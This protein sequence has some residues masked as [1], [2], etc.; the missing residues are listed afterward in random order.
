MRGTG[1][2]A[3]IIVQNLP[4]PLDRRVW[5]ESKALTA[6]GY[7]VSVICP[8]GPDDPSYQEL[9]EIRIYKY[10]PPREAQGL[11]GFAY[12]FGYC[13]LATFLL[14]LRV[15]RR[16]RFDVIQSCNPPDTFGFL[17][18]FYKKLFGVR[19]IFDQ[20]DLCPEVYRSRFDRPSRHVLRILEFFER[21]NYRVADHV[22]ATNESYRE[23]AMTRGQRKPDEV[24]V[25]RSGPDT[26]VMRPGEPVPELRHGRDHLLVWLGIMGPQDGV[27][28]VLHTAEVLRRDFG[29]D[30]VH[31]AL[32]GFGDC[33][34]ELKEL[35]SKLGL[36]DRVT[37]TGRADAQTISSYLSTATVGMSPDPMNP[38]NN[39]STMNKTMEYM[40]FGVPVVAFDLKETRVSAGDAAV[41]VEPDDIKGFAAAISDLLDAPHR[42]AEMARVGRRRA[43]EVLDWRPQAA[44]Y[45]A[46][47]DAVT[48]YGPRVVNADRRRV[49]V[50]VLVD[51]RTAGERRATVR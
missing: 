30:D 21:T 18:A 37:F 4:V 13:W 1:T 9:E 25:V 20:H 32:L 49:D 48:G 17:A 31:I 39:L 43:V 41:M 46:V 14:S 40:A 23:I 22:I 19:F 29:R 28:G 26:S 16:E 24:T 45:V 47:F 33:L 7:R 38:L 3:L 42:R 34:E 51:R 50:V 8:K 35:S 15:F 11:V 5:L 2:H 12:E 10:R 27:D 44:R 36:D 6:A